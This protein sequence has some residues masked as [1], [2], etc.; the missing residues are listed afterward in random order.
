MKREFYTHYSHALER[1][2]HILAYGHAGVPLIAFPCQDGMCDNWESFQM[3]DTLADFI[4][5]G[6]IQ[7]FCVDTVDL[8]SWSALGA[9]NAWRAEMQERYYHYFVDEAYPWIREINGTGM[10]PFVTGF[11]LGATHSAI[12]FLR[13]PELFS[14]MLACS[15][16]YDAKFAWGDWLNETL[17]NNTPC[18]FLAGMPNDH[19]YISIYNSKRIVFCIGQGAW[20]DEGRRT[21]AIMRDIFEQK[22]INAWVDFWGFDV[23]HDWPWWR[24]QI[25]YFLPWMLEGTSY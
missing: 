13:R 11:S 10:L 21:T 6:D 25:R 23:N 18:N 16:I 2:M 5:N 8:E 3:Q 17:Y 9:D 15:G 24:K 12:V 7:L 4:E 19:E 1:E 14:G 22:G 20:E